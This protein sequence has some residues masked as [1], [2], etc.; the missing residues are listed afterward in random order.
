MYQAAERR[1]GNAQPRFFGPGRFASALRGRLSVIAFAGIGG[2]F[3]SALMTA[4]NSARGTFGMLATTILYRHTPFIGCN[5]VILRTQ[6][7]LAVSAG[8]EP[9]HGVP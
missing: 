1:Y 8:F 9:A 3:S 2:V 4:S 5:P 6:S 7:D